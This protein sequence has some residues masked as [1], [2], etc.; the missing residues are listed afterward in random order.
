M[1]IESLIEFAKGVFGLLG[2]LLNEKCNFEPSDY[3]VFLGMII[4]AE[5]HEFRSPDYN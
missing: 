5:N 2:W 3:L 1:K 4:D